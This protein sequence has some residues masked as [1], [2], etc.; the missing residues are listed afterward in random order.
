MTVE[1]D[2]DAPCCYCEYANNSPF[3]YPCDEC[4]FDCHNFKPRQMNVGIV[5]DDDGF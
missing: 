3:G 2:I 1:D 5:L 4:G